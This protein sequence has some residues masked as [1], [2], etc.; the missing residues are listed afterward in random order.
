MK[1]SEEQHQ[2]LK[3]SLR[4]GDHGVQVDMLVAAMQE[5]YNDSDYLAP[6]K[7]SE[8]VHVPTEGRF[9]SGVV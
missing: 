3:Q 6:I 5:K 9:V 7:T 4:N 8:D 2:L 1:G